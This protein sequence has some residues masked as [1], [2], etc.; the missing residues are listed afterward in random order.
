MEEDARV[1]E[2]I[3]SKEDV[4]NYFENRLL[5]T[6]KEYFEYLDWKNIENEKVI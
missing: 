5:I 2:F 1:E 3:I 6:P 4:K